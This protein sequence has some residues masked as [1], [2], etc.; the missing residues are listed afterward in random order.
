M[1][2]MLRNGQVLAGLTTVARQLRQR[3]EDERTRLLPDGWC[4]VD[5]S[6]HLA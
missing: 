5:V 1:V 3:A 6:A 4:D 2:E